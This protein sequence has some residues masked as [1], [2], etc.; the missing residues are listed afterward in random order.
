MTITPGVSP[1][2]PN[3][4]TVALEPYY[5]DG[6]TAR[7][8]TR[9]TVEGATTFPVGPYDD[10]AAT[11]QITATGGVLQT[12]N[13]DNASGAYGRVSNNT[14]SGIG[15]VVVRADT[16]TGKVAE[17]RATA[18]AT[19]GGIQITRDGTLHFQVVPATGATS[20][21]DAGTGGLTLT[22]L[23][24]INLA[25]SIPTSDPHVSG[26]VWRS[27]TALQVSLG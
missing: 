1:T 26:Q 23:G 8:G 5:D 21:S 13:V 20:V 2:P 15:Q 18:D 27:G 11:H 14:A 25:G 7:V 17:I 22:G 3:P 12:S 16:T 10:G 6:G 24:G 19:G 4:L 9:S